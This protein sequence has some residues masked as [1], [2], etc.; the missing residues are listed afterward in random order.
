MKFQENYNIELQTFED[1]FLVF[2]VLIDDLYKKVA[3]NEVKFRPNVDKAFLSDSEIITIAV[4]GEFFGIDSEKAWFSLV[5]KNFRHLFPKMCDRSQFNRT[6]RNL[7]QVTELIFK[8]LTQ[9]FIDDVFLVDSF[10]LKV[11]EFG[12]AHF[13]K[14]FRL[15]KAT[16]GYCA[17]KKAKFFGYKVHVLTTSQGAIISFSITPA[18]VDDRVGLEDLNCSIPY[19][20]KIIGDK[21]YQSESLRINLAEQGI[22]LF[23]LRRKN[24]K[25]NYPQKFYQMIFKMRRRIETVF[26][27]LTEQMKIERVLA[28]KFWGLSTRLLNKMLAFNLGLFISQSSHIKSLVF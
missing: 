25:E 9:N 8:E 15:E 1:F 11:C 4:C 20:S 7:M 12:R 6:R 24:S 5:K 17:T 22:S 26:S 19:G 27:Q 28:K 18:N 16:Y 23:A 10:P 13:C 14:A 3:P 21:G 2:F